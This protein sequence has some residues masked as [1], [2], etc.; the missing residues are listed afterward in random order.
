LHGRRDRRGRDARR[1]CAR[2]LA[3]QHGLVV[4]LDDDRVPASTNAAEATT[5][6]AVV[7]AVTMTRRCI[8]DVGL[9]QSASVGAALSTSAIEAMA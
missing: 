2:A 6:V 3:E 8:G 7:L 4:G 9:R 1:P 5:I